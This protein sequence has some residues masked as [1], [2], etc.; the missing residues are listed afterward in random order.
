MKALSDWEAQLSK[1]LCL[2]FL[3]AVSIESPS[4]QVRVFA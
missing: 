4:A 2:F 3:L 1:L